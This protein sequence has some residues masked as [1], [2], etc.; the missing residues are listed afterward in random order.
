MESIDHNKQWTTKCCFR[1]CTSQCSLLQFLSVI[2]T[3]KFNSL[4]KQ[5]LFLLKYLKSSIKLQLFQEWASSFCERKEKVTLE[6]LGE[7]DKCKHAVKYLH[8]KILV[9]TSHAC[10]FE[11]TDAH[12]HSWMHIYIKYVCIHTNICSLSEKMKVQ[13]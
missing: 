5:I 8:N 10:V 4:T 3:H 1:E 12:V 13:W 7:R 2:I 11:Y 9:Y 6:N